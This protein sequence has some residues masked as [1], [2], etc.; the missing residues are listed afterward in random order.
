MTERTSTCVMNDLDELLDL[1]R[2]ALLTG[3]LDTIGRL[4]NR[5]EGLIDELSVTESVENEQLTDL[6]Q[7]VKRNQ[8]LLD[9]ALAG[10]RSVATRLSAMRRVRRTLDTYDCDGKKRSITLSKD[11]SV[12]KRA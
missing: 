5:K 3:K 7:K 9:S 4:I 11:G 1:E 2:E 8:D 12:E 10:I 6:S